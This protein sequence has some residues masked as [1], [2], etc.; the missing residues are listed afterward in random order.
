LRFFSRNQASNGATIIK[1]DLGGAGP[2]LNYTG[3]V[4]GTLNTTNDGNAGTT[5][6]QN[7]AIL[8]TSFLSSIAATNGSYSLAGAT[9][10]GAPTP[11]GGGVVTQNFSGGNFKLYNS[12][13]ALLLD[14]NLSTSL[15]VGGGSGAF[16]NITN[17][18]VVGG[19]PAI[20]SQ[21]AGNSIGMSISLTNIN[22]AGGPGLTISPGNNSLNSFFA[23][24]T[25]EISATQIPE[26]TAV[27]LVL[28]GLIVPMVL[29]RRG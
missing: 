27:L 10:T 25:K 2:D 17:G 18:T 13:N 22:S 23:D 1:L 24:A 28:C 21:L 26:P 5:G 7:T 20:T 15:L 16:F 3:G 9:A 4:F 6:D 12:S 8:Y 11:L 14:V 19:D 29:R